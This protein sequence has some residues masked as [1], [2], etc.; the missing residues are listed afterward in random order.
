MEDHLDL[1]LHLLIF[2]RNMLYISVH[3]QKIVG[4]VAVDIAVN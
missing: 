3:A 4:R 2:F 1:S